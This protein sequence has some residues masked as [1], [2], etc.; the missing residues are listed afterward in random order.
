MPSTNHRPEEI[1]GK[2]CETEVVLTQGATTA[3]AC[4]RVA[5]SEQTC[6]RWR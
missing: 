2:L 5:I 1:I 4:C 3:E 6:Y